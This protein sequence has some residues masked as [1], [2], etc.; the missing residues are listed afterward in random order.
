MLYGVA[1]GKLYNVNPKPQFS[2]DHWIGSVIELGSAGWGGF[3][4]LFFHPDGTL[5]GVLNGKFYKG[6]IREG[7][8]STEWIAQATQYRNWG[9]G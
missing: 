2:Q 6:A 1:N 3:K 9:M 5:Y 4:L 8:S 7:A